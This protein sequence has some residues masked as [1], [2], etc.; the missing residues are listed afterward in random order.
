[1]RRRISPVLEVRGAIGRVVS[2]SLRGLQRRFQRDLQHLI[3]RIHEMQLHGICGKFFRNLGISFSLSR[4]R[5]DLKSPAGARPAAFLQSAD[6][7]TLCRA[8]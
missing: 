6:G 4:G 3:H 1:M 5:N 8:A 7:Q 2:S